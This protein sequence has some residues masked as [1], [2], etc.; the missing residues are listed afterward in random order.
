MISRTTLTAAFLFALLP[1][2]A[3]AEL[4]SLTVTVNGAEPA[5]TLE[6]SLFDSADNFLKQTYE[7]KPCKPADDGSCTV[8]FAALEE[9]EYA[10]VVVHDA[11]DNK[12][13]DN[14]FLGFGAEPFA[15]SNG[16]T[17]PLFGRADFDDAKFTVDGATEIEIRL[18]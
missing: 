9:G 17:N 15:Y 3:L 10:V 1:V 5:G 7:Q 2:T 6:I 18:D 16:A 13:L 4:P 11:N 14:G 8:R 12:K